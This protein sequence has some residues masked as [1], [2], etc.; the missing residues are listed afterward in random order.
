M[1]AIVLSAIVLIASLSQGHAQKW[2][3]RFLCM[4]NAC[5]YYDAT[6]GKRGMCPH[7]GPVDYR[8]EAFGC[9]CH[10]F[11]P[12]GRDTVGRVDYFGRTQILRFR[13]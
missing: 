12:V 3:Y 11:V 9:Y 10:V 2:E 7:Y 1:R 8:G 5:V 4:M 6:T 13:C